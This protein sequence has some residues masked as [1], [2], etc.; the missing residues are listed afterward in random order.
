M[1]RPIL[2]VDMLDR[3]FRIE[4]DGWTF[5]VQPAKRVESFAGN[6]D[7]G[8]S[9]P[10]GIFLAVAT[11]WRGLSVA[12]ARRRPWMIAVIEYEGFDGPRLMHT[13]TLPL[14]IEPAQRMHA[15]AKQ[16]DLGSFR[17]RR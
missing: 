1:L 17:P 6:D 4:R 16:I 15:I 10:G 9:D 5:Y 2:N 11:A 7:A 14:G 8:S 3:E 13:E 12:F